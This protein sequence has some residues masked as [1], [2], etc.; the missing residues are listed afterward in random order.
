MKIH[1]HD[2]QQAAENQQLD[3]YHVPAFPPTRQQTTFHFIRASGISRGKQQNRNGTK[4]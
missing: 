4:R 1:E 3:F 2:G